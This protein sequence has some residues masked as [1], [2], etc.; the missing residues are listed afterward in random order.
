[1]TNLVSSANQA[2]VSVFSV[3]TAVANTTTNT[4]S[5]GTKL[6]DGLMT[7]ADVY[8]AKQQA[9]VKP[10]TQLAVTEALSEVALKHAEKMN[11][12]HTRAKSNNE[13]KDIFEKTLA[14]M[15]EQIQNPE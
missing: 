14:A 6:I 8:H 12:I 11:N 4:V 15:V 13:V 10:R 7:G 9:T 5:S 2:A 3:L 1:M